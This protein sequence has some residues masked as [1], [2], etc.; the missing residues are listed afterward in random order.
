[1]LAFSNSLANTSLLIYN[2]CGCIIYLLVYVDDIII[3]GNT[4]SDTQDFIATLSHRF[5]IKD[6]GSFHYFL[7]VEVLPHQHGL[8]L[9]Q[10]QYIRDLLTKTQMNGA[11]S[12]ATLLAT[13]SALT[14]NIGSILFDPSKYCNVVGCLQY[15]SLTRPN[16]TY[17]VSKLPQFMHQP[18]IGYWGVVKWLLRY[19]IGTLDHHIVL[20]RYSPLMF[21]TFSDVDWAGNKDDFTSTS[22][23]IV[24]LGC[25]PISWSPKKQLS[26]AHSSTKSQYRSVATTAI[27]VRW[28]CS[29]LIKLGIS[30]S[31]QLVIYCDNV[32]VM[33]FCANPMF[34]SHMKHVSLDY[35]FIHE[36]VLS[37]PLRVAHISPANL[38]VNALTKPLPRARFQLLCDKIGLSSQSS[39]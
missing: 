23:F 35:H 36:Q 27:E 30:L 8:F 1:M 22:A 39:I 38:L 37:G 12:V 32:G 31:Q 18:T 4:N 28:I 25:N 2:N 33:N 26:V 15:L 34:H 29:L 6:I 3:I 9:S 20:Y 16:V 19:L 10:R 5:S 13:S 14:L 7:G 24:Y 17:T 21:Q 11:N